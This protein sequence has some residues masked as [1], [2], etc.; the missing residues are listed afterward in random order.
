MATW[1][2]IFR[3]I[4][5][6]DFPAA[7]TAG[8]GRAS[9]LA[10]TMQRA[11][12]LLAVCLACAVW[13]GSNVVYVASLSH[14]TQV[15]LLSAFTV[16]VVTGIGLMFLAAWKKQWSRAVA[17]AYAPVQGLVIGVA[18][19][20]A[21]KL[22]PGVATQA[23][24]VTAGM[25]FVLLL[26]YRTGFLRVSAAYNTKLAAAAAGGALFYAVNFVLSLAG[27]HSVSV[28]ASGVPG[29]VGVA[30]IAAIGA[31]SLVANFDAALKLTSTSLPDYAEW[32]LA[33]GLVVALVWFY[34]DILFL[35]ADAR[36]REGPPG[37]PG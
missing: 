13:A 18:S 5:P 21:D 32:Y 10:G 15:I 27:M 7:G 20:G 14:E 23:V 34:L 1:N 26:A 9:A 33:L 17:A 19:A 36:A 28:L 3:Y 6:T 12:V 30:V 22:Y 2:P 31:M 24:C 29:L 16:F 8:G 35:M 25:C 37:P 11:G 4:A